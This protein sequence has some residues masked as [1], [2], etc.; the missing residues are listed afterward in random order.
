[1]TSKT[2]REPGSS[3][4]S[5]WQTIRNPGYQQNSLTLLLFFASWGVWWSFF[6]IWLTSEASGLS[7]NGTQVGTVYAANAVGTLVIMF[8]YGTMQDRLGTRRHLAILASAVM[9]LV[10]PFF[11]FVYQPLLQG[12]FWLGVITGAVVLSFGFMAAVGLLE[13]LAEKCSRRHGF[14]Y[15]Q[16]RMWGSFGYALVALVA[17]FLFT[18]NPHLMFW[19][20]SVFGFACLLIQVRRPSSRR[21][22]TADAEVVE[23]STPS[24][25]EMVGLLRVKGVWV[26]ILLVLFTWTFYTVYDQQM[27]PDFYTELFET[28]E[29][30][31]HVYGILNS[32]QVFLEAAMMGVVP[33][34]MHRV[35]VRTTL[36]LGV[37]VMCL[38]ILGTAVFSDP[39]LVSIIKM[40]HAIEVPLFILRYFTLHFSTA[41]SATLYLVAFQISAQVGNVIFSRP[42]GALRD[43]LGYQPTF[44]VISGMVLAAGVCAFFALKKD[45]EDVFGEPLRSQ[46]LAAR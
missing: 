42:L 29:R 40:F 31:Q 25:A 46:P 28:K 39:V 45:D 27:F 38:R 33:I 15:G 2:K 22:A 32:A 6:Q 34:L 23:Q 9:S 41:L 24:V 12:A 30:G 8:F 14:E 18:I 7:L 13:A 17:G 43:A 11:V 16:A 21:S 37:S 5:L 26:V 4:A 1:M 20:G 3:P 44:Y 10:G 36:M 19:A 35:G